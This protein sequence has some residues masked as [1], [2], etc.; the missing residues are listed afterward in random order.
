MS[1]TIGAPRDLTRGASAG[2]RRVSLSLLLVVTLLAVVATVLG[3]QETAT[4]DTEWDEVLAVLALGIGG[5]VSL[6][7]NVDRQRREVP[8]RIRGHRLM[9]VGIAVLYF[10]QAAGFAYFAARGLPAPPI[11]S[12]GPMTVGA[13]LLAIGLI[14]L[15][16]PP[17]MDRHDTWTLVFDGLLIAT[18]LAVLWVGFLWSAAPQGDTTDDAITRHSLI[19][20][21][22]GAVMV[23]LIAATSRRPGALPIRQLVPLQL[24]VLVYVIGELADV[25]ILGAGGYGVGFL[26]LGAVGSNLSYRAFLIRPALETESSKEADARLVWS[27]AAPAVALVLAALSVALYVFIVGPLQTRVAA[28]V[29]SMFLIVIVAFAFLRIRLGRQENAL[30]NA[31]AVSSLQQGAATQWFAALVGES[32]DLV[33]VIDKSAVIVYQTPS[34]EAQYGYPHGAFLGRHLAEVIDREVA[35]IESLLLRVLHHP[36]ELE[37]HDVVLRDSEGRPRDTETVIRP[38]RVDGSEGF[39]LTTRDVTDRRL[40]RA[41]LA[42]TGLRD[43]L[44]GLSNREGF[45]VR[46][47]QILAGGGGDVVS[48]VLLDLTSFRGIND[49]RGHA[50]GDSILRNMAVAIDR[51]PDTVRVAARMGADE[52]GL[53][54]VADPIQPE[55]GAIERSLH[56]SMRGLVIDD[57]PAMDVG[58]HCGYVVRTARNDSAPDLVE[59]ADLALSAARTTRTG[60]PVNYQPG[61]RT[62]LVS[63]LRSE[64]DLREALDQERLV[65]HYQPVVDLSRGLIAGVEALVRMRAVTGELV[66]PQEFIAQAEELGLIDQVGSFVMDTAFRDCAVI[67]EVVGNRIRVAVNVSP[68]E[69]EADLPGRVAESL[70]R[71]G[72]TGERVLIELTESA[73]VNHDDAAAVLADLRRLGCSVAIDDFGTGYS[74]LSYLV[75]LPV[76]EVKIDR[77]FVSQLGGSDRSLALVRVLLQMSATLGL[78]VTAEGIETVEQADLL[79]GMGCSKAQGFLFAR[80]MGLTDL[81]AALRRCR[82]SFPCP[83]VTSRAADVTRT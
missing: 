9:F 65:V 26:L 46:L 17:G 28:V 23:L 63:R 33:T 44:T 72:I 31:V 3:F 66:P 76:D 16:W 14:L 29:A 21:F 40:L 32:Q 81:L 77:S 57:G 41:E 38:L 39:V 49:S 79:R 27:L 8:G 1:E 7:L 48:V 71:N 51:L 22:I 58:F 50:A 20:L 69:I 37:S 6:W 24:T 15:C 11:V 56:R 13:P 82:G 83:D 54:V 34:L 47:R 74:S 75:G 62:A 4:T 35:E 25:V 45:M 52:F 78:S 43:Q 18:S 36:E 5:F 10:A 42:E 73:I 59:R 2:V 60:A 70:A 30:R 55:V 67:E 64:A 53:V 61:M 19:G 80:P 68:Q 12:V